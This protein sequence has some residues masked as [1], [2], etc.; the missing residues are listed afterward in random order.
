MTPLL[1]CP[2]CGGDARWFYSLQRVACLSREATALEAMWNMRT[3]VAAQSRVGYEVKT[4][5]VTSK[6]ES[7]KPTPGD[8]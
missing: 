2:F 5:Q 6:H 1:P 8:S 7:D 3:M 4:C